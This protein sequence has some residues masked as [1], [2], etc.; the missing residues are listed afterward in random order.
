MSPRP[1]RLFA[2][3]AVLAAFAAAPQRASAEYVFLHYDGDTGNGGYLNNRY[4]APAGPFHW[5][6]TTHPPTF[7]SQISTFCIELTPGQVLPDPTSSSSV[8]FSVSSLSADPAL[9]GKENLIYELYGK[10]F[11]PAFNTGPNANAAAF[12][13]ALWELVYDGKANNLS[14]GSFYLTDGSGNP[15]P[16]SSYYAE[17]QTAQNWLNNL[18]ATGD[19]SYF[20]SKFGGQELVALIAPAIG[21]KA[22]ASIQDQILMRPAAVP[23]PPAL[24]LA[25]VGLVALVGRS[26]LR[27][28]PA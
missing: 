2:A 27:R 14:T 5:S 24:L 28:K 7:T 20:A 11:D 16:A 17:A 26:R 18:T 8:Q 19:R 22:P 1:V 21:G 15:L 4:D 13:L 12:Q 3:A 9:A 10:H 23:A 25:G 6:D